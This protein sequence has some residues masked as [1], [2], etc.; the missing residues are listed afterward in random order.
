MSGLAHL[1]KINAWCRRSLI[2]KFLAFGGYFAQFKLSPTMQ[3]LKDALGSFSESSVR[4][5]RLLKEGAALTPEQQ[6]NI[7][8]NIVIIQLALALN[9]TSWRR[10]PSAPNE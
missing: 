10:P 1:V 2:D 7:E 4:L 8:N 6:L 5:A 9:K 3:K